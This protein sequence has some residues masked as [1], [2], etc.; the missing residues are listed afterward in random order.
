MPFRQVRD[1]IR[2]LRDC[3][4][5]LR[6]WLEQSRIRINN[7]AVAQMTQSLREDE[8][9]LQ[10]ALSRIGADSDPAILDTWLQFSPDESLKQ[11]LNDVRFDCDMTIDDIVNRKQNFDRAMLNAYRQ[12]QT[13]SAAPRVQALF[14][15]LIEYS[16]SRIQ[17]QSWA[18]RDP[19][20]SGDYRRSS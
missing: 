5:S 8:H 17:K 2:Q 12:M 19:E 4:R 11:A 13:V 1:V 15:Q 14:D 7:A 3:H 9:Q 18:I 16:E 10:L 20:L 6:E